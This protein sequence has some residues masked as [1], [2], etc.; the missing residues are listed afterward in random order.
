MRIFYHLLLTLLLL[1][2][3]L[4]ADKKEEKN[5]E[6]DNGLK[7]AA[8]LI[9]GVSDLVKRRYVEEVEAKE[10]LTGALKGMLSGL[11]P[12]S[13]YLPPERF[14]MSKDEYSGSYV[15][16]GIEITMENGAVKVIS[17]MDGSPAAK[18]GLK[19]G[20]LIIMTDGKPFASDDI[21][22][23]VDRLRG[24]AGSKIRLT[25]RR[26]FKAPFDI[27]VTRKRIKVHPVKWK[28]EGDIG[29]LR[30]RD[31]AAR[32]TKDE[33]LSAIKK[34]KSEAKDNLKGYVL[35]LRNNGGGLLDQGIDVCDVF[36]KKGVVLEV[37]GRTE[38]MGEIHKVDDGIDAIKGKPLVVLINSGSASA[39]EIVAGALRDNGRAVIVGEK[40]FGKGSIQVVV[41]LPNGGAVKMTVA[42]FYT[43]KGVKIQQNGIVPDVEI[44]QIEN[45]NIH[46]EKYTL[47]E[48]DLDKSIGNA[49]KGKAEDDDDDDDEAVDGEGK[50][51]ED[52]QLLRALDVCRAISVYAAHQGEPTKKS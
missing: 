12:H 7:D 6:V 24:K 4:W 5:G 18:A 21:Y 45:L 31:F 38:D 25:I 33:L 1:V 13:N 19:P 16:L 23:A 20:D 47:R 36:L 26:K 2:Q 30:I 17:P 50:K 9:Y 34:I 52:Y 22:D 3:P 35:D 49:K 37:K 32:T 41:P 15:G 39:S 40:S 27:T 48:A 46:K 10:L 14:K 11:D 51:I 43:P 8:G 29:Y 42:L 44:K 28:L